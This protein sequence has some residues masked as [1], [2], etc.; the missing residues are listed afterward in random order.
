M[1]FV[2]KMGLRLVQDRL[3]HVYPNHDDSRAQ[4]EREREG[5]GQIQDGRTSVP[6]RGGY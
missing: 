2:R 5:G 6:S 3:G 4:R 1:L